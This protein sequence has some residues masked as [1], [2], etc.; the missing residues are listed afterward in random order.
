MSSTNPESN[1]LGTGG[2]GSAG[3]TNIITATIP[4]GRANTKWTYLVYVEGY[5]VSS[6]NGSVWSEPSIDT[7][8]LEA[9]SAKPTVS[10]P[11][12]LCTGAVAAPLT[13][14]GTALKWYTTAT[15]GMGSSTAPTPATAAAGT[16]S[17]Y[18]TQ[19]TNGCESTREEIKVTVT[20]TPTVAATANTMK[21]L[22]VCAGTNVTLSATDG[23]MS[24]NWKGPGNY[25]NNTK[26]PALTAPVS[27]YY[28]V[29]GTSS[30][31][32]AKDSV[33]LTVNPIPVPDAKASKTT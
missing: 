4:Q 5:G 8:L 6:G 12:T 7:L 23:F 27:G 33:Q 31:G 20:S 28:S 26:T 17:Y 10:P 13:A 25:S 18:V 11:I 1:V 29:T 9:P 19:N 15:G 22:Q 21:P 14:T 30:C 2:G 3:S 16:T 24:Y 32:V